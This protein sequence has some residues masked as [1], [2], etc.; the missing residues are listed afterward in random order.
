MPDKIVLLTSLRCKI[1]L[2]DICFAS[3]VLTFA[4]SRQDFTLHQIFRQDFTL[5][6]ICLHHS[7]ASTALRSQTQQKSNGNGD[8][9]I[10]AL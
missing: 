3:H 9:M 7:S 10:V 8:Y 2:T 5:H 1:F 6:Q 4:I